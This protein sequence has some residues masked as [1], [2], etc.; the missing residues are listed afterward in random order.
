M[1][2]LPSLKDSTFNTDLHDRHLI[3]D[4]AAQDSEGNPEKWR[5]EMWF[6]N[7]DRIVYAIHGGPMAGRKNFQSATY[8][9][10][11]P[12]ELWQCNWLEETGT[13]CSLVYD[14]RNKKITT[15]LGF[16]RGHWDQNE[17]AKGDKRNPKDFER[18]RGLAKVGKSQADRVLLSEQ[19]DIL[20]DFRGKGDL[21]EIEM[22]W[23][24]L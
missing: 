17:E 9:C 10:I 6:Y 13:I 24:T 4:Y 3:Y 19:A 12:G 21:E 2:V 11:R 7:E 16:S 8:Q 14:I 20:E 23:P 18:W 1:P 22:S 15:L 5:Y